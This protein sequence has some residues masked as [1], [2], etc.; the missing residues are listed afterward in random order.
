MRPTEEPGHEVELGAEARNEGWPVVVAVGGDGTHE[1]KR[2]TE[3][4]L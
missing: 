1:L 2:H 3:R 4:L